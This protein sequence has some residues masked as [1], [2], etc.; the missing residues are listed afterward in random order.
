MTQTIQ[1]VAEK[2]VSLKEQKD[3]FKQEL[4]SIK[5]QHD[6]HAND[7]LQL[8][9][10]ESM[11]SF[12]ALG[13]T[14]YTTTELRSSIADTGA[15]FKYLR[16]NG[17]GDVIKE[18]VHSRTLGSVVKEIIASGEAEI[19]ELETVGFKVYPQEVLRMRKA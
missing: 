3:Y 10:N 17:K 9:N 13:K 18:T 16:D 7:L 8:M 14:F 19:T 4:D 6:Q 15:A 5:E 1:E 11:E 2:L 12:K